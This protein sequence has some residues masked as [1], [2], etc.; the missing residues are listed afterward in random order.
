MWALQ[1][2]ASP[3][4]RGRAGPRRTY[5]PVA[6]V[7][8]AGFNCLSD[9]CLRHL[10]NACTNRLR[11]SGPGSGHVEGAQRTTGWEP[12]AIADIPY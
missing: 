9:T 4:G 1:I 7:V 6:W 11:Q 12:K 2:N 8:P 3:A 10:G 5:R